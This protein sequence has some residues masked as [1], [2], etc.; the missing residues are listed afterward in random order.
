MKRFEAI[1]RMM[2][3]ALV[4][5]CP[6]AAQTVSSFRVAATN[7]AVVF[8]VD[9][10]E[11]KGAASF[12][13]P[14]GSKHILEFPADID[15]IQTNGAGTRFRFLSWM[16]SGGL[17]SS[18]SQTAITVSAH[19]QVT[20]F[21][22]NVSTEYRVLVRGFNEFPGV[23][24]TSPTVSPA[25]CGSPGN[26][27]PVEFRPGVFLVNGVCYWGSVQLWLPEGEVRL[28]AYP[29]PGFVFVGW[30]TD[31]GSASAFLNSVRI[32]QP[33]V[34]YPRFSPAKRVSFRTD[35]PGL[36]V[37]VDRAEIPTYESGICV[38]G[39]ELPPSIP[40]LG[41]APLCQGEFDFLPG[42]SHLIGA[43]SPQ[44]DKIGTSWV[45]EGF[46]NGMGDNSIYT[47]PNSVWP[48]ETIVARF[49]RGVG[50]SFATQPPG[51]KL[52]VNGRDNW[53]ALHFTFPAGTKQTFS[54]AGEQ[55]FRG[56]KYVFKRWSNGGPA[57]QELTVPES[58]AGTVQLTAEY[59][60]LSQLVVLS[61]PFGTDLTVDG[62]PC[63]TPCRVDRAEGTEVR[64]SAPERNELSGVHRMEFVSWNDGATRERTFKLTGAN[65]STLTMNY[66]T[67]FKLV[68][69][70][71]PP[72][73]ARFTI[74][75]A[76]PDGFYPADTFLS[77]TAGDQPGFRF[78]RWDYDLS[79]TSRTSTLLMS[80]PRTVVARFD[81][82]PFVAPAGIRNAAGETP[83]GLLAPGSL[84]T[85]FG[86]NLASGYE[87]GPASPLSQALSGVSVTVGNRI[88]PL[89]FVS[90]EQINAQLPRDLAPGEHTL[91]VKRVGQQDVSGKFVVAECAPGLFGTSFDSRT[92][93]LARH[94]DGSLI[95]P[96]SPAR[97]GET[98]TV[99][100]TGFG[101]YI[102][103]APEGFAL[104]PS[105]AY[106][107]EHQVEVEASG[108]RP[109]TKWAGGAS[110]LVGMD[111]VRF[112]V[113]EEMSSSAGLALKVRIN[114]H[115]S[116]TVLLPV[117]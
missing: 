67:S 38:R 104:P 102:Y 110:G 29:F 43:P 28:N 10:T 31:T 12:L 20:S 106:S 6:L 49:S 11:Y 77:I 16:D 87:V 107:L 63:G 24:G 83:G 101:R 108:A 88:L 51:L 71:D 109:P 2:I 14:L 17:A 50:V 4:G 89:M 75:P 45:F 53:P 103:N 113:D 21:T 66:Q 114:G 3:A 26:S 79:G 111:V 98:V 27:V 74:E 60:L 93:A 42:S 97:R 86:A 9:G 52:T 48:P 78:R 84:I 112:V 82:V 116:N 57:S 80:R 19:P 33:T 40:P 5:G 54:A 44:L 70:A 100:G 64:L 95:T 115:E 85:I 90:P 13:W 15:G 59:D 46:S 23:D 36:K 99:F 41:L 7:P 55:E 96:E 18:A 56:R 105:P 25:T 76:S 30:A 68:A 73:G 62:S 34:L 65:P 39:G 1:S 22:L 81:P 117:E 94:E 69:A 92:F 37:R 35:P 72:E 61:N 91:L 58:T 32:V 8:R 47:A